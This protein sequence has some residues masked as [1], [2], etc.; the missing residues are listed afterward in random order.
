MSSQKNPQNLG[1]AVSDLLIL[2]CEVIGCSSDSVYAHME[3]DQK[4]RDEGGLG[5]LEIPLLGDI[6]QDI[7]TAF[8]VIARHGPNKGSAFR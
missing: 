3:Y 2:D 4:P 5:G 8:G 7:G 6:S 1:K